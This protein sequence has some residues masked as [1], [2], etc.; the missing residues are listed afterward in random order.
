MDGDWWEDHACM[1][2]SLGAT[3]MA[4]VMPLLEHQHICTF[5]QAFPCLPPDPSASLQILGVRCNPLTSSATRS[6]IA[7]EKW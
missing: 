3:A 4:Y 1:S 2:G 6:K 5:L 7:I